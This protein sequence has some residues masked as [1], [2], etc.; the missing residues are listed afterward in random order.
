MR[1][2]ASTGPAYRAGFTLIELLVVIAIVA[3]LAAILFPVF[4]RARES[5]RKASCSNNMKQIA[6]AILMY[7]DDSNGVL[8]ITMEVDNVGASH[9]LHLWFSGLNPYIRAAELYWCPSDPDRGADTKLWGSYLTNGL[10]TAGARRVSTVENP[11]GTILLAERARG[12]ASLPEH[13]PSS[14]Y[15]PY[16][17]LCYDCWLPNGNW[18]VGTISWPPD[19]FGGLLDIERHGGRSNYAFL[20]GHV[21]SLKWEE[22]VRSR[23]DN[24]H[25]LH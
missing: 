14:Q 25:D 11:A 18:T 8:P 12:W 23:D 16:Y 6:L 5:A 22:T 3:I 15:S 9:V 17:D 13:D 4:T 21:S 1:S 19:D 7:A 2:H 24:L 10:L 20:D